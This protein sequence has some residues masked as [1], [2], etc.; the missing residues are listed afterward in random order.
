MIRETLEC[1][2]RMPCYYCGKLGHFI[3]TCLVQQADENRGLIAKPFRGAFVDAGA[4]LE[5]VSMVEA[6]TD[7]TIPASKTDGNK[8]TGLREA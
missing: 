8:T 3:R 7:S 2:A 1:H 4:V 6:V 5:A